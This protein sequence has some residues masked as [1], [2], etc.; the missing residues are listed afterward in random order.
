MGDE[1]R[2]VGAFNMEIH[3]IL[4]YAGHILASYI[5]H[6]VIDVFRVNGPLIERLYMNQHFDVAGLKVDQIDLI[7]MP[8]LDWQDREFDT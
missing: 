5:G 6:S 1:A 2:P 4:Y 3:T 8:R 7:T